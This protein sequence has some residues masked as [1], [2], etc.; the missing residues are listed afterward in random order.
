MKTEGSEILHFLSE[1]LKE[2]I[3]REV[4]AKLLDDNL[5][6]SSNFRKKF[7]Y[8][9]AKNLEEKSFGPDE[10]VF[11]FEQTEELSCYFLTSGKI[12][13]LYERCN[14]IVK[15]LRR[16]A[17][18]GLEEFFAGTA[19]TVSARSVEF[20]TVFYLRRDL[21]MEKLDEYPLDKESF[22]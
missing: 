7:L 9:L 16:G 15:S 17:C 20:S 2:E 3:I 4:N 5:T 10:F 19:R 13:L 11:K 22:Q 1:G 8:I 21:M 14:F 6:F 18:F 12:D